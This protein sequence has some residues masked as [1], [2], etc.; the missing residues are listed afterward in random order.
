MYDDFYGSECSFHSQLAVYMKSNP[1][2][3]YKC[4]SQK[5]ADTIIG[6]TDDDDDEDQYDY[7]SDAMF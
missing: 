6:L 5:E 7:E 1:N 3:I 4:C 2:H